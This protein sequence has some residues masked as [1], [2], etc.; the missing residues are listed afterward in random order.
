MKT[1]ETLGIVYYSKDLE[2][3]YSEIRMHL[4]ILCCAPVQHIIKSGH[5][6]YQDASLIRTLSIICTNG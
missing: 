5:F 4:V 2:G 1:L 3:G 6:S